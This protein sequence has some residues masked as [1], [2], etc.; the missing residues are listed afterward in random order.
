MVVLASLV[1][2][3]VVP[4]EDAESAD[5]KRPRATG[6]SHIAGRDDAWDLHSHVAWGNWF[7]DE[8]MREAVERRPGIWRLAPLQDTKPQRPTPHL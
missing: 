2:C 5:R 8:V 6:S 1:H 3:I 4:I 7:G